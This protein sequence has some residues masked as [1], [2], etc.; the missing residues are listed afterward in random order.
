LAIDNWP[1][2]VLTY[3]SIKNIG[4]IMVF[5]DWFTVW[6]DKMISAVLTEQHAC[7]SS[8]RCML[9]LHQPSGVQRI[10]SPHEDGHKPTI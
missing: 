10:R 9:S 1:T 5:D 7:L 2:I 3:G 4:T 6:S 8:P